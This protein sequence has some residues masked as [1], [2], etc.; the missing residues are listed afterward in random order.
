MPTLLKYFALTMLLLGAVAAQAQQ[1]LTAAPQDKTQP[2]PRLNPDQLTA[3]M[4]RDL[5]LN[6]YQ[7]TRLQA[8]NAAQQQKMAAVIQQNAGNQQ[9]LD[10][11]CDEACKQRDAAVRAVLSNEQY[12]NYYSQRTTY[13][14]FTKNYAIQAGKAEFIKSVRNPPPASSRGA[15]IKPASTTPDPRPASTRARGE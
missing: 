12:T 2:S 10:Q 5:R 14:E 1:S 7:A 15:V 4:A 13:N 6:G 8:I 9:L 3:R 11:Q